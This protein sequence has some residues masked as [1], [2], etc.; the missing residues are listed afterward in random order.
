MSP[1]SLTRVVREHILSSHH[2][3]FTH[4]TDTHRLAVAARFLCLL[5]LRRQRKS[6][7]PRTGAKL[8]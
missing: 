1:L 4:E 3:G 6:V 2:S 8:I 5:S 7:P